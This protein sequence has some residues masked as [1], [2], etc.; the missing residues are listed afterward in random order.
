LSTVF[1]D[2]RDDNAAFIA[3]DCDAADE[4]LIL[5]SGGTTGT[6]K[7]AMLTHRNLLD[8]IIS[9]VPEPEIWRA[10]KFV[11]FDE[12]RCKLWQW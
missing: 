12:A 9:F 6:P 5:F 1:K 2:R 8:E 11:R 10:L 7:G 3:Q 4:C